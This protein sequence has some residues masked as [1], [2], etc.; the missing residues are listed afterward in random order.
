[1]KKGRH[2]AAKKTKKKAPPRPSTAR[3]VDRFDRA[4]YEIPM[5][6]LDEALGLA[7]ALLNVKPTKAGETIAEDARRLA[8][9]RDRAK[10]LAEAAPDAETSP[11]LRQS[12]DVAMDRAWATMVRRIRDH[13]ELPVERHPE[14]IMAAK[15]YAVVHD[16]SILKLNY[17]AEFAQIGARLDS[18]KREGLFDAAR[19]FAGEAFVVEVLHCHAQYGEAL[20]L[21]AGDEARGEARLQLIEAISEYAYQVL[22][23][24]RAGHQ[25]SWRVVRDALDPIV[26]LRARQAEDHRAKEPPRSPPPHP[27]PHPAPHPGS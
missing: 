22:A 10:D 14:A 9:A 7:D 20:G 16:L 13:A 17:L 25:D 5:M 26:R 3:A 12:F 24:A 4:S 11:T 27:A 18:L 6:A 21:T 23:L 19:T 15:V 2:A 8:A 1:M